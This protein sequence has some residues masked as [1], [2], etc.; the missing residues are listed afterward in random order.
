[1]HHNRP[2]RITNHQKQTLESD[3][4]IV[5]SPERQSEA[6]P[7]PL[8][9]DEMKTPAQSKAPA[10]NPWKPVAILARRNGDRAWLAIALPRALAFARDANSQSP[11][12]AAPAVVA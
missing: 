7:P 8:T 2:Q 9:P 5:H 1:M 12:P 6:I 11:K 4:S 10:F 3:G